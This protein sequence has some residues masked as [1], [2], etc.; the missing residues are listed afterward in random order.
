MIRLHLEV[1]ENFYK[2][3][4]V[5]DYIVS[6]VL[7]KTNFLISLI[8]TLVCYNGKIYSGTSFLV[9]DYLNFH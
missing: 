5:Y 7:I 9:V 3:H 6:S 2:S 8:F 4:F 1:P